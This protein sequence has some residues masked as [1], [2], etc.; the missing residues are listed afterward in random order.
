LY[1]L[2]FGLH[3]G[4]VEH[5]VGHLGHR[6]V[7]AVD[8][9]QHR[10]VQESIDE[11]VD[12]VVE[13][14]GEQQT[15]AAARCGRQDAG[16]AGKEAEIGHVIGFVDHRDLDRVEA[17]QALLHQVFE[18]ANSSVGSPG[19]SVKGTEILT[20]VLEATVRD[21]SGRAPAPSSRAGSHAQQNNGGGG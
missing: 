17:D 9:V 14:C 12:A 20:G 3:P 11:L 4:D 8:R 19:A 1:Q 15:L 18:P 21:P 7:G 2:L 5:V 6:R 13:G 16:D 10:V